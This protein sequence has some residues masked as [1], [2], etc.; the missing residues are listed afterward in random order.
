MTHFCALYENE[1]EIVLGHSAQAAIK[2]KP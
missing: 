2:S 1:D